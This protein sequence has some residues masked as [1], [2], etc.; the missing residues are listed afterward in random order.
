MSAGAFASESA[1]SSGPRRTSLP[2]IDGSDER[3][4]TVQVAGGPVGIG[5]GIGASTLAADARDTTGTDAS[6]A[7]RFSTRIFVKPVR[8][9]IASRYQAHDRASSDILTAPIALFDWANQ[10]S[11]ISICVLG[12][13]GFARSF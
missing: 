13:F 12:S 6:S 7:T 8:L 10:P 1:K 2:Q 4:R 3:N 5:T 9:G 11:A